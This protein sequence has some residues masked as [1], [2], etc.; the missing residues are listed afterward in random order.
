MNKDLEII[1]NITRGDP[2]A[3]KNCYALYGKKVYNIALHYVQD[4]HDAEEVT[5]EVFIKIHKYAKNFKGNSSV[6]TWIYRIAVNASLDFIKTRKKFSF[7]KPGLD[8]TE[9]IEFCH[10]GVELDKKEDAKQLYQIIQTLPDNQKTAFIL[11]FIEELPRQ[12]VADTMEISLKA[13]ESLLQR[14]KKNLR[15]KLE[16]F[17]PERRI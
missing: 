16:K 14:A 10:P 11:S 3:F 7:I 1:Q 12:E 5:Q 13:I 8:H 6:N 4:I 17:Y 9:N 2:S 15:I